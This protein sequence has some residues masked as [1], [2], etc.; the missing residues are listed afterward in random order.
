MVFVM[1]MVES[2]L[3]TMLLMPQDSGLTSRPTNQE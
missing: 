1:L 3:S 2:E